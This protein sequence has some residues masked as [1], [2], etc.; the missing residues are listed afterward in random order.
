MKLI[1]EAESGKNLKRGS[2]TYGKKVVL[3]YKLGP[4][5]KEIPEGPLDYEE[6]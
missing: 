4:D 5:G 3:Q 2:I 1:I 6:I